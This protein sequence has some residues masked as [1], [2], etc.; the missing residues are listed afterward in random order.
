MFEHLLKH[1]YGML[2]NLFWFNA[3]EEPASTTDL[4]RDLGQSLDAQRRDDCIES[5]NMF[6]CI[7]IAGIGWPIGPPGGKTPI[8]CAACSSA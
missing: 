6:P 4:A 1:C 3:T 8:G 2:L 7:V 5:G